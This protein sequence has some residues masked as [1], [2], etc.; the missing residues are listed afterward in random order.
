MQMRIRET[1]GNVPEVVES[2]TLRDNAIE[3][4]TSPVDTEVDYC[5]FMQSLPKHTKCYQC[6]RAVTDNTTTTYYTFKYEPDIS[7]SS[8]SSGE[9]DS[10]SLS[11]EKTHFDHNDELLSQVS[12]CTSVVKAVGFTAGIALASVLAGLIVRD[13]IMLPTSWQ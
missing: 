9:E 13:Q 7:G 5:K 1:F 12:Y 6:S 10:H 11:T 8:D 4:T 2:V 3:F